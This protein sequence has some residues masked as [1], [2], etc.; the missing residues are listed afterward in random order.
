MNATGTVPGKRPL[1]LIGNQGLLIEYDVPA[2]VRAHIDEAEH[3]VIRP[4]VAQLDDE[5]GRSD[6]CMN[7]NPKYAQNPPILLI[8]IKFGRLSAYEVADAVVNIERT[9]DEHWSK[10]VA[11][12]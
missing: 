7:V 1:K 8:G 4:A 2:N 5:F 11:S 9:F 6:W 10:F 12:V 3:R